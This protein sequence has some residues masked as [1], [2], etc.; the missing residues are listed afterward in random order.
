MEA[1][2]I[3]YAKDAKP[4]SSV[5]SP[6][7]TSGLVLCVDSEFFFDPTEPLKALEYVRWWMNLP[8]GDLFDGHEFL[9]ILEARRGF[10]SR[11]AGRQ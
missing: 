1:S 4:C 10:R 8:L 3:G 6:R 2:L 11:S 7:D 5:F 9:L